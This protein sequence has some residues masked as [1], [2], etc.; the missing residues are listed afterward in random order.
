VFW[1]PGS[2]DPVAIVSTKEST[3]YPNVALTYADN[4]FG[5]LFAIPL[6]PK[7]S[8]HGVWYSQSSDGSSWSRAAKLPIDGPRSTNAP[9][10]VAIDS[11]G[12]VTAVFG[13]NSGSSDTVCGNPAVSRSPDGANWKTCGPGK[14]AG[15]SFEVQPSTLHVIEAAND[16]AY[17]VWQQSADNKYGLGVLVWHGR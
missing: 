6:D 3:D 7:D 13:S 8:D 12:A 14:A 11:K 4:R 16:K 1:R 17:V 2:S 10:D 15:T 9:L 5:V